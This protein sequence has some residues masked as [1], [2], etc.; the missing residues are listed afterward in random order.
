[1]VAE[2]LWGFLGEPSEEDRAHGMEVDGTE[3]DV[4]HMPFHL[5]GPTDLNEYPKVGPTARKDYTQM[6]P[7]LEQ[8]VLDAWKQGQRRGALGGVGMGGVPGAS[9]SLGRESGLPCP[10]GVTGGSATA[11]HGNTGGENIG[12]E[13]AG[14]ESTGHEST[15]GEE[16][17]PGRLGT[18]GTALRR[19]TWCPV[20]V[21]RQ[22][23]GQG[24]AG[25]TMGVPRWSLVCPAP[26]ASV[27]W[28]RAVLCGGHALGLREWRAALF[29]VSH[30]HPEHRPLLFIQLQLQ[31]QLFHYTRF[32]HVS[33]SALCAH[34]LGLKNGGLRSLHSAPYIRPESRAT[35]RIPP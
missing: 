14:H 34:A 9:L 33:S 26:W 6:G 20:L 16:R 27:L 18:A 28:H 10:S 11:G 23:P 8:R 4:P 21:V 29:A 19:V 24:G 30:S 7:P 5:T 17:E 1:M 2:S 15:E 13:R 25:K 12:R 3:G 31:L 35:H 32:Y 22:T